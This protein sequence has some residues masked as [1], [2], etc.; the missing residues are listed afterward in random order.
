MT[1]H[2]G[3][4]VRALTWN[5]F[6]GRDDP[7]VSRESMFQGFAAVLAGAE[8]DV[9]LLQEAPPRWFRRLCQEAGASGALTRTS[10]NQLAPLRAALAERRPDLMK[11]GEGG[12]N[13]V[14]VR[15]PWRIAGRRTLTLARVPE[16]RRMLWVELEDDEARTLCVANL[17][18]TAHRPERAAREVDRAARTA[19]VWSAGRPLIFGGDLNVRPAEQPAAFAR[20]ARGYGL[21]GP[22]GPHAIDHLM[23]RLLQP[24]APPQPLARDAAG[25]LLSDH[26]PLAASF[27]G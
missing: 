2:R 26:A 6:H 1:R 21:S 24:E 9:A 8:W 11:S 12:S 19:L 4:V 15:P 25:R 13:Q 18:A 23:G 20:L 3:I 22:T 17:H 7:P 5:L 10:R 16:R 27:L 14:L